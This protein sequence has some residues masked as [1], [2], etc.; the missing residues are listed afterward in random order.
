[1]GAMI[2]AVVFSTWLGVLLIVLCF[3]SLLIALYCLLFMVPLNSFVQRVNSLGG[4]MRGIRAHVD[5]VLSQADQR[6]AE[7]Q[8]LLNERLER[9]LQEVEVEL[10]SHGR[11]VAEL[12][13]D[14]NALHQQLAELRN[15]FEVLE[16]ELAGRAR[17]LVAESYRGLEGTVLGALE[18]V[19]D[20]MLRGATRLRHPHAPQPP[21][22]RWA[23]HGPGEARRPSE[24]KIISALPLFGDMDKVTQQRG[25]DADEAEEREQEHTPAS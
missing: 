24:R 5:E 8:R 17:T 3:G 16:G 6:I 9:S 2:G 19:R 25:A 7:V 1:M 20:E 18:A 10:K 22:G 23:E 14:L 4:G 15:D 11:S 12:R 21:A 13:T